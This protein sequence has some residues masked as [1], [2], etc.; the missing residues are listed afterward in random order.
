MSYRIAFCTTCKGRTQHLEQTLPQNITDNAA[1]K[2]AVFVVVNYNSR[3]HLDD[4]VIQNH[5]RDIENGKLV[6]YRFTEPGQFRMAHAKNLSHR[7]G[8]RE[9]A[10]I[11]VNIDA[12]NFTGKD[13]ASY[14]N[15]NFSSKKNIFMWARMVKDGEG[16]LPRGISGRIVVSKHAFM[17]AGG[18]DETFATWSPDDKD[19]HARLKY[20]GYYPLEIDGK[21]LKA[22]MHNDKMRFREYPHVRPKNDTPDQFSLLK[23]YDNAEEFQVENPVVNCGQIGMG[24]VY[25]NYDRYPI[26]LN[27]LPTRIFGIGMHKT[28]TTSLHHAL[29]KLGY[30]SAHWKD[31]HWAKKIWE[32][33]TTKGKSTTLEKS[34]ALSDFPIPLLYRE[35]DK[36][37]KGSKFIL[38][39]RNESEWIESVKNHWSSRNPFRYQWDTDPFTHKL[40][41]I[42]YGRKTFD[43]EVFLNKYRQH[44]YE[45]KYYFRDR[46]QD[47]L[48][49]DISDKAGWYELCGF[50]RQPIPTEPYPKAYVT[51]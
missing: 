16:R 43:A 29:L 36:A 21:Y 22:I 44:N 20:L 23:A 9:G 13:F 1:Y 15:D 38:T 33:M 19:F 35:L 45:V 8:L 49:M 24:V 51:V 5:K 7:L 27:T 6:V 41:N 18:Y 34:F 40:H 25:R 2:N 17:N 32:E 4:F 26:E 3:D 50:L 31:A 42:V 48:V 14:I 37:Y 12:D 11:L 39:T 10:D 46:P 28:G 47:L 30:D